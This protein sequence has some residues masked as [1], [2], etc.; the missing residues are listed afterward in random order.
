VLNIVA[1][2]DLVAWYPFRQ[3]TGVDATAGIDA[4]GDTTDYSATVNGATFK[5][6]GGVT[7]IKTGANSGAF[8]F[9]GTDDFLNTTAPCPVPEFTLM[10]FVET[11]TSTLR[12]FTSILSTRDEAG[13][14]DIEITAS[15]GDSEFRFIRGA[16]RITAPIQ[17][18]YTHLAATFD[19]GN[20]EFFVNGSSVGTTTSAIPSSGNVFDIGR[21]PAGDNLYDGRADGVRIYNSVLSPSQINQVF[22]NT[23]P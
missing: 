17:S 10:V 21:R 6:S 19:S 7:D 8:D 16:T 15:A 20:M 13:Q 12:D 9:D 2:S 4:F 11:D 1:P 22:Q 23:K 5:P 18:P 3:G 14:D